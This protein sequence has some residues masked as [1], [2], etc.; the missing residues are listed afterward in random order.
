M[1][2]G[3]HFTYHARPRLEL[4]VVAPRLIRLLPHRKHAYWYDVYCVSESN[5]TATN[6][7]MTD[8]KTKQTFDYQQNK[9]HDERN[10]LTYLLTGGPCRHRSRRCRST[11]CSRPLR[12]RRRIAL[13][14]RP[15]SARRWRSYPTRMH[16][17]SI[18][19]HCCRGGSCRRCSLSARYHGR[20]ASNPARNRIRARLPARMLRRLHRTCLRPVLCASECERAR[21]CTE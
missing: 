3:R 5:K 11:N 7:K 4:I 21:E 10:N 17:E 15:P 1:G 9:L 20:A 18:C 6:S 14:S 19:P 8:E 13:G 2:N 12:R 16:D